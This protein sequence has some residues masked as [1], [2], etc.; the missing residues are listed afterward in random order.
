MTLDTYADLFD[1]GVDA[2]A[3]TLDVARTN[4]NVVKKLSNA[5][6]STA[7]RPGSQC[8]QGIPGRSIG[9]TG[10]I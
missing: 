3:I 6:A 5:A 7:K 2:V 10:G 4:S 8:F 1:E 9:G